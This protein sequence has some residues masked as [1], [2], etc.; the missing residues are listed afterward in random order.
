MHFYRLTRHV[1]HVTTN[2]AEVRVLLSIL[3][4]APPTRDLSS[5]TVGSA[6]ASLYTA[7]RVT[8]AAVY[9]VSNISSGENYQN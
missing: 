1:R 6:R 9:Y 3:N 5:R 4:V 7:R 8:S 2:S